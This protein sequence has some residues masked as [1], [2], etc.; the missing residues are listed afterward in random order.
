MFGEQSVKGRNPFED[1][2]LEGKSF[3]E[4]VKVY[5]TPYVTSTYVYDHIKENIEGWVE[6]AIS[7]RFNY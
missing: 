2:T 1:L 4:I 5:D 6:E 3:S 7:I